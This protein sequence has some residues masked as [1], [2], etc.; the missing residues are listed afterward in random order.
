MPVSFGASAG[1]CVRFDS[2]TLATNSMY[3]DGSCGRVSKNSST[4][5]SSTDGANGRKDSRNLIRTF[6]AD[7]ICGLRASPRDAAAAECSRAELHAALHPADD[8][9]MVAIKLAT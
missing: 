9:F 5:S 3:G 6:I 7:C 1:R 2:R 4:R 8:V